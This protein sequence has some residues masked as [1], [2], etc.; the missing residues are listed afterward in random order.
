MILR[1]T[2]VVFLV[3]NFVYLRFR[4]NLTSIGRVL[5]D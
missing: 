2:E 4:V 1:F 3:V 5:C